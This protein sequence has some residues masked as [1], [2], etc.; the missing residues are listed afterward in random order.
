[1]LSREIKGKRK[2]WKRP[3]EKYNSLPEYDLVKSVPQ[4]GGNRNGYAQKPMSLTD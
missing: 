1:M 3:E 4:E 2:Q